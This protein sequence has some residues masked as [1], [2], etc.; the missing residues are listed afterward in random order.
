MDDT[1]TP[2]GYLTYQVPSQ[3]TVVMSQADATPRRRWFQFSLRTLLILVAVG[4][5]LAF[6]WMKAIEPYRLQ[7]EA[8]A[9][10]TKLGGSYKTD[11][12]TGWVRYLD[13]N[14]QDVVVVD[15]ADCDKLDEYLPH[16]VRLPKL[17]TLVVGGHSVGDEQ[18]A[19]LGRVGSLKGLVLDST[20]VTN[21]AVEELK[22]NLPDLVV[23]KSDRRACV[24]V[25]KLGA[26]LAPFLGA[27]P[28]RHSIAPEWLPW[29][30]IDVGDA[31][32]PDWPLVV[33][34]DGNTNVDP[35]WLAHIADIL[36]IQAKNVGDSSLAIFA[37]LPAIAYLSLEGSAITDEGLTHLGRTKTL[38]AL[39][40]GGTKITDKGISHLA[41]CTQLTLLDIKGTRISPNGIKRLKAA[42]PKC[43]IRY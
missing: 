37:D 7:R 22:A 28:N 14:A 12:A 38:D 39:F 27:Y 29:L 6:A 41:K 9:V 34:W 20:L 35:T 43:D 10:I 42:L 5:G 13:K 8:M 2:R 15:L 26:V 17:R 40:I 16:L 24:E 32:V 31:Y 33:W 19:S 11:D 30:R 25:R 3:T 18:I 4:A 23:Y 36:Q 1:P 21:Q